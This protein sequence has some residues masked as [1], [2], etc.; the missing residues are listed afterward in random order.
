MLMLQSNIH[1]KRRTAPNNS[2]VSYHI[3]LVP[4]VFILPRILLPSSP[5]PLLSHTPPTLKPNDSAVRN[6][7]SPLWSQT[8]VH[9]S[10]KPNYP[11][12]S[13]S[14]ITKYVTPASS[15]RFAAALRRL[16]LWLGERG[17]LTIASISIFPSSF[18]S[19]SMWSY[20]RWLGGERKRNGRKV[21][22]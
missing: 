12:W 2:R 19:R 9:N 6:S 22:R 20:R 17:T 10:H 14:P 1:A 11:H 15:F 7:Q 18:L 4:F 16:V 3:H 21:P 5:L 8:R 13:A